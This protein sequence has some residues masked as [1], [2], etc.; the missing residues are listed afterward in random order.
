M[1]SWEPCL[2]DEGCPPAVL[3]RHLAEL[4]VRARSSK[5]QSQLMSEG[6]HLTL[7]VLLARQPSPA[8]RDATWRMKAQAARLLANLAYQPT[9]KGTI[10]E[11]G[12]LL[13]LAGAAADAL[14]HGFTGDE[15]SHAAAALLLEAAAAIGNLASGADAR[16]S[17]VNG[18]GAVASLLSRMLQAHCSVASTATADGGDAASAVAS[19]AARALSN[20]SLCASTHQH[21]IQCGALQSAM[22]VLVECLRAT[23]P[24]PPSVRGGPRMQ[25]RGSPS[26][27][28]HVPAYGWCDACRPL[29]RLDGVPAAALDSDAE[30]WREPLATSVSASVACAA[31]DVDEPPMSQPISQPLLSRILLMLINLLRQREHVAPIAEAM[32]GLG[33]TLLAISRARTESSKPALEARSR[34]LL[35]CAR[36]AALTAP[37]IVLLD[38]GVIATLCAI[39][40]EPSAMHTAPSTPSTPTAPAAHRADLPDDIGAGPPPEAANHLALIDSAC[41]LIEALLRNATLRSRFLAAPDGGAA[42]LLCAMH[43]AWARLLPAIPTAGTGSAA[44]ATTVVGAVVG[45]GGGAGGGAAVL[46]RF[47]NLATELERWQ[48][49]LYAR[50]L[51]D[52]VEAPLWSDCESC[53]LCA[54]SRLKQLTLSKIA[55]REASAGSVLV[56]APAL[57]ALENGAPGVPAVERPT[58]AR[59]PTRDFVTVCAAQLELLEAL[60]QVVESSRETAVQLA[61]GG[62]VPA[63][64]RLQR[65]RR[66]PLAVREAGGALLCA[67][68]RH[69]EVGVHCLQ[70]GALAALLRMLQQGVTARVRQ[71]ASRGAEALLR[72]RHA[73]LPLLE[74]GEVAALLALLYARLPPNAECAAFVTAVTPLVAASALSSQR[75]LRS[76][77]PPFLLPPMGMP[78]GSPPP[79]PGRVGGACIEM[80]FPGRVGGARLSATLSASLSGGLGG[81]LGGG[82]GGGLGS[83]LSG[84]MEAPSVTHGQLEAAMLLALYVDRG[85]VL[86]HPHLIASMLWAALAELNTTLGEG[87]T[88]WHGTGSGRERTATSDA[89]SERALSL[90]LSQ[91]CARVLAHL[92]THSSAA[93]SPSAPPLPTSFGA[94]NWGSGGAGVT[95]GRF[96]SAMSTELPGLHAGR[97]AVGAAREVP[98]SSGCGL[99]EPRPLV[100]LAALAV[101]HSIAEQS[102]SCSNTTGVRSRGCASAMTTPPLAPPGPVEAMVLQQHVQLALADDALLTSSAPPVGYV[103]HPVVAGLLLPLP[104]CAAGT[105]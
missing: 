10:V 40:D 16:R 64:L 90:A 61:L 37:G 68:T 50:A 59:E 66:A 2:R 91:A 56:R 28:L 97:R 87:G 22:P 80:G 27:Q 77:A 86:S 11:S 84:T 57:L 41:A 63:L 36:L 79:S 67:I 49:G 18:E 83:S 88:G 8:A 33:P 98:L 5:E 93:A 35:A 47:S 53:R 75:V 82:L 19:E 58:Y 17:V 72:A 24:L 32:P 12:G 14:P 1:A 85:P 7:P 9:H 6:L 29:V 101:L 23:L 105:R 94:V 102:D 95:E 13:A 44:A 15:S 69:G 52:H 78:M 96:R 39:C 48:P 103:A 60:C 38:A 89:S 45:V 70:H 71:D 104:A 55:C 20:L 74:A 3:E 51:R 26:S 100:Q 99:T 76:R 81:S 62:I 31:K 54:S 92:L 30:G 25:V 4:A 21:L 46:D 42:A 43:S 65:S 73:L 34:A